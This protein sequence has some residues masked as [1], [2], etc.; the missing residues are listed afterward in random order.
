[1]NTP[2][3]PSGFA[4]PGNPEDMVHPIYKGMDLRDYFA[5]HASRDD[6]IRYINREVPID[7]ILEN[8]DGTK[9]I[10]KSTRYTAEEARYRYADAMMKARTTE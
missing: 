8:T 9:S 7:V 1:M 5:A 3:F 6:Y 4:E 2:A 10:Y